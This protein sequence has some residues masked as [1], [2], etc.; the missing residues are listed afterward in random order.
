MER[1][2]KKPLL[3]VA[4]E[5]KKMHNLEVMFN[6]RQ[7][8]CGATLRRRTLRSLRGVCSYGVLRAETDALGLQVFGKMAF[9]GGW[10]LGP[11]YLRW[12]SVLT[13]YQGALFAA[14]HAIVRVFLER[15]AKGVSLLSTLR[16]NR[17]RTNELNQ[18]AN[19]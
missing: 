16:H 17:T 2:V 6:S 5:Q 13:E 1:H 4:D 15:K 3:A 19:P 7:D 14:D 8:W 9:P 10:R 11:L 18:L 12:E